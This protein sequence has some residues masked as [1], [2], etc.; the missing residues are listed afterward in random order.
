MYL[1]AAERQ[2]APV[3]LRVHPGVADEDA[4]VQPPAPQVGLDLL[5]RRHVGRVAGEDPRADGQPVARHRQA[6]HEL[7]DVAPAVLR[8]AVPPQRG[9]ALAA[10]QGV[11]PLRRLVFL[12]DLAV[13]RGRVVEDEV[14]VDVEQVR[15]AEVDRLL[16]RRLVG[17]EEVHRPV[18]VVE[19]ERRPVREEHLGLQPLLPT[20]ELRV[21]TQTAVGHHGEQGALEPLPGGAPAQVLGQDGRDAQLAATGSRGRRGRRT[22]SCRSGGGRDRRAALAVGSRRRRA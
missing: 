1:P 2:G 7:R 5:D 16:D 13:E 15:H 8:V 6:D 3:L 22:A 12:V 4:A 10:R 21:G 14:D 19:V 18:E 17:L 11:A 9:I 20:G